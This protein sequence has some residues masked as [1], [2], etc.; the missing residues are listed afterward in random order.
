MAKRIENPALC[1]VQS[2]IRFL[3]AK[4]VR[5]AEIGRQIVGV[6]GDDA[7]KEGSVKEWCR[8]FKEDNARPHAAAHP[9]ALLGQLKREIFKDPANSPE[10]VTSDY[11]LF[12][13]LDKFLA[14]QSPR[15]D[16]ETKYIVQD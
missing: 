2:V 16:Q 3:N 9:R 4:N 1:E 10:L 13:H 11:R 12:F 7:M 8:F 15:S 5:P 6:Y 14:G